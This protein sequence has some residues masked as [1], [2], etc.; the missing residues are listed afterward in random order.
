MMILFIT[1]AIPA[2]AQDATG[3]NTGTIND[4]TAATAGKPTLEEV[5]AD[6][7]I[8]KLQLILCGRL[9]QDFL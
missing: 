5:G 3:A 4:V 8:T 6:R 2:V 9:S 1:I 7:A